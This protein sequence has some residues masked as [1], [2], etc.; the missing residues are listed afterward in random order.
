[1]RKQDLVVGLLLALGFSSGHSFLRAQQVPTQGPAKETEELTPAA[2]PPLVRNAHHFWDATNLAL[3]A[4]A[5]GARGLDYSSSRHFRK[6]GVDEWLLTNSIVDNRS[7]FA[8]IDA[9]GTAASIAVA[10]LFHR[11]GHHRLER[12]VSMVHVGVGVAG[13]VRNYSLGRSQP[14]ARFR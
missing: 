14:V 12:W 10:Y 11:S 3:F 4:G 1:M 9:A 7:L 5:G 8:G 6:R 13:S 2:R